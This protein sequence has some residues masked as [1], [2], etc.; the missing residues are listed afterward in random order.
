MGEHLHSFAIREKGNVRGRRRRLKITSH[1]A[2]GGLVNENARSIGIEA[3]EGGETGR[4]GDATGVGRSWRHRVQ[5]NA[6]LTAKED[7]AWGI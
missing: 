7:L 4:E 2:N 6:L 5:L 1:D 3:V